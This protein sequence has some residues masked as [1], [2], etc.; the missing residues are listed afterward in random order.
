MKGKPT[1]LSD[2]FLLLPS[3]IFHDK[4]G[5]RFD[6]FLFKDKTLALIPAPRLLVLADAAQRNFIR[7]MLPREREQPAPEVLTLIV[8]RDE[9]LVEIEIRQMQRQTIRVRTSGADC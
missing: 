1:S 3:I 7:Q 9:Q 8:R 4:S 6:R 5:H 2:G